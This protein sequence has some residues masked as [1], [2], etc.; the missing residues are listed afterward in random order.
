[1]NPRIRIEVCCGSAQ[2]A[3]NAQ[4]G[5]AHRV[6]LCQNPEAGGTTPSA[7]EILM[8]R[9]QLSIALHVLIRPRD[10]DFLY[11]EHELEIVRQDILFC[12]SVGVNGVVIG[13]LT[14]NGD[15]DQRL[16]KEMIELAHPMSVTF[17]R[18]F[19]VC[20]EP[21]TALEQLIVMGV[22]RLLTSG[23]QPTAAAGSALIKQLV[24]QAGK[25]LVVMPGS[26]IREHNIQGLIEITGAPEYHVSA[27][28][29][30]VSS[31][32]Y[33]PVGV[34]MGKNSNNFGYQEIDGEVIR[35]LVNTV[36]QNG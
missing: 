14:K 8:A 26:G 19:D 4:A 29:T 27:R 33:C 17:H 10:G 30:V 25:R 24:Q 11:S 15:I 31:M 3:I 12:K 36:N 1:M 9:K 18:A 35:R 34:P 16:T 22:D 20:R 2:S 28:K 23:Q 21:K 5:G 6:E 7:G 13:F 32:E